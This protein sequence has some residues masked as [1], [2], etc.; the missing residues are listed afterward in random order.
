MQCL[1]PSEIAG[2][3]DYGPSKGRPDNKNRILHVVDEITYV[4]TGH[5]RRLSSEGSAD[6][7]DWITSTGKLGKRHTARIASRNKR[8]LH[9]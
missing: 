2:N 3:A 7:P 6:C 8:S 9:I 5:V 4:V 1:L